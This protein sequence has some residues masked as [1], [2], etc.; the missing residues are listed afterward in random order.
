MSQVGR[1]HLRSSVVKPAS[2]KSSG[3]PSLFAMGFVVEGKLRPHLRSW[4]VSG[5][6]VVVEAG[7]VHPAV[8][9]WSVARSSQRALAGLARCRRTGRS[10]DRGW[11]R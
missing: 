11:G 4:S 3:T 7:D 9:V 2:P 6:D 5:A 8:G 10:G 1:A